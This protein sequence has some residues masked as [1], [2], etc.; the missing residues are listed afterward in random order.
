MEF[1]SQYDFVVGGTLDWN[2]LTEAFQEID[3]YFPFLIIYS[4]QTQKCF[5]SQNFVKTVFFVPYTI[6]THS[7]FRLR[8]TQSFIFECE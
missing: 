3:C 6:H 1:L 7:M 8:A 2:L 4:K 5:H